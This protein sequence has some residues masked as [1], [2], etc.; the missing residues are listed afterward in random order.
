MKQ[1]AGGGRTRKGGGTARE[2]SKAVAATAETRRD[3]FVANGEPTLGLPACCY[4]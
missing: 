1:G 4:A 3:F 2:A